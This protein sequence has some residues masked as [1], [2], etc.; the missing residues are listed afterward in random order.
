[1]KP[2][3][4]R[5]FMI[6]ADLREAVRDAMWNENHTPG[7]FPEHS[8]ATSGR[9]AFSSSS[10]VHDKENSGFVAVPA[11]GDDYSRSSKISELKKKL[12]YASSEAD[13]SAFT[14]GGA[15]N[16]LLG[17]ENPP[18]ATLDLQ[19]HGKWDDSGIS[20]GDSGDHTSSSEGVRGHSP[21]DKQKASTKHDVHVMTMPADFGEEVLKLAA[22]GK[23][24]AKDSQPKRRKKNSP[25]K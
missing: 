23:I 5:A 22:G 18:N 2:V 14:R 11:G 8:Q 9:D 1:M 19:L 20:R 24:G 6:P 17:N 10:G 3:T 13:G 12:F 16:S 21:R 4:P 7:E 25:R 15:A